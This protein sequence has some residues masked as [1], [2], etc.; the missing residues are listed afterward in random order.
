MLKLSCGIIKKAL[1]KTLKISGIV[2]GALILI[3]VA[4]TLLVLFDKPLVRNI[5]QSRLGKSMGM[6]ARF[7]RLDSSLFPFPLTADSLELGQETAFQKMTVFLTRLEARG[8]FWKLVRGV[9]PALET[10][11]ADGLVFRL[12]QKA[13]SEEPLDIEAIL[14]QA[15]DALAWAQRISITNH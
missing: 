7:G 10:I 1:K 4:A 14:L 15:S 8:E 9:K 13:V 12:E 6:P 2:L 3:V 5:I 11:E